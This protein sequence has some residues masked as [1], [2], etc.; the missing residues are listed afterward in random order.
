M[1]LNE[2]DRQMAVWYSLSRVVFG[3]AFVLAPGLLRRWV[4]ED[5]RRPSVR[6]LGRA[7]GVRDLALGVGAYLAVSDDKRG[8]DA[9]RW[10]QLCALSDTVDAAATLLAARHLRRRDVAA[11]VLMATGG[12]ATGYRLSTR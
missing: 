3:V 12:A 11:A 5:A 4:G 9:R 8:E 10:L 1:E 7:F 6:V 2:R